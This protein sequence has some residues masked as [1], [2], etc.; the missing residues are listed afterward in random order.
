MFVLKK[1][2]FI[3]DMNALNFKSNGIQH[4]LNV[5]KYHAKELQVVDGWN[6]DK[7][8]VLELLFW[9]YLEH[10]VLQSWATQKYQ[11]WKS[12]ILNIKKT[13]L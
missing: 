13:S 5:Q 8:S 6:A 12:S 3:F 9:K 10:A 2:P 7:V 11:F 1:L 4:T